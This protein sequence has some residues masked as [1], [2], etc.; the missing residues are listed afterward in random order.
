MSPNSAKAELT[1]LIR[2]NIL[3]LEPYHCAREKVLEGVLLDA[4]ENPFRHEADG[5]QM[6]RY[7]D[8][9]QR[10]VRAALS[11]VI[12][13][14]SE[15][16]AAGAGSDEVL[17][18]IF[19]VFCQPGIDSVV[20]AEPTYGMYQV[21]A[22]IFGVERHVFRLNSRFEFRASEFLRKAPPNTKV[23]FLCSPNNP[24][25]NLLET[26]EV[27]RV[28]REWG[29][30]VVLDQAY[31]D[32]ARGGDLSS[33]VVRYPNLIV[34][35]TLSKA[36]GR[37]AL[38]FGYAI[39]DPLLTSFFMKVKAPY[40]LN[41]ITMEHACVALADQESKRDEVG[42]IC[43]ERERVVERL[44]RMPAVTEV[45]PSEANFLLFRCRR[46]APV[47]DQL[48]TKGIVVRDRSSIAGLAD[49]IRITI[50]TPEENDLLLKEL[51]SLLKEMGADHE[52]T[53]GGDQ[54][55]DQ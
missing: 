5:I 42:R 52:R 54:A 25:G 44:S 50:G 16:F 1:A 33:E 35:R 28:C 21:T 40:N 37:A 6:N 46:A 55:R 24:T 14:P 11:S 3:D 47:V 2:P 4:N 9:F 15:Y 22:Q 19:K 51:D 30:I 31:I 17:E 20:T 8:P 26:E 7:P 53:N 13:L 34:L 12:G 29:K 36:Y 45:F 43:A 27:L 32:F 10:K 41:A 18:W 38:R 48:F 23:L 49:C 39:A